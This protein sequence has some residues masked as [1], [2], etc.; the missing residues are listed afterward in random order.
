MRIFLSDAFFKRKKCQKVKSLKNKKNLKL[1]KKKCANVS[2]IK[3]KVAQQQKQEQRRD[4][5]H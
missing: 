3:K 1:A 2:K 5:P 4:M